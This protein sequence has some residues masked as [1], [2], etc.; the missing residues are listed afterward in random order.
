MA[1]AGGRTLLAMVLAANLV[2][3]ALMGFFKRE[4]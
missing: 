4:D 2:Q 1:S 3:L